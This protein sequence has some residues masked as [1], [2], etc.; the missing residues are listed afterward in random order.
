MKGHATVVTARA[1]LGKLGYE[2]TEIDILLESWKCERSYRRK[3]PTLAS[4]GKFAESGLLGPKELID[5]IQ[6][7]GY[8][9]GDAIR[10]V[11]VM[12]SKTQRNYLDGVALPE[13]R[14]RYRPAD[15]L[16]QP[17]QVADSATKGVDNGEDLTGSDED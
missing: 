15:S 5:R 12:K 2:T 7:L 13:P 3:L 10:L 11:K 8:T 16:I 6:D 4:L 1:A 17:S 14:R 9:R